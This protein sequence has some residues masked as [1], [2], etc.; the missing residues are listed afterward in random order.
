VLHG[1]IP[2]VVTPFLADESLDLL[3]L[4]SH[5]HDQL[6]AGVHDIFAVD[7]PDESHQPLK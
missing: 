6:A 3:R 7:N 5:I 1:I 2:P 4:K